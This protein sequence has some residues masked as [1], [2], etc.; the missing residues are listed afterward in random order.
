[1]QAD[2]VDVLT[3]VARLVAEAPTLR[4]VVGGV[5]AT[6][7][8][9]FSPC[10]LAVWQ[11][12]GCSVSYGLLDRRMVRCGLTNR[13]TGRARCAASSTTLVGRAG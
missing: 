2:P 5:A 6:L 9:M 7:R 8:A 11:R 1:M 12:R 10:S 13:S 3:S 4:E